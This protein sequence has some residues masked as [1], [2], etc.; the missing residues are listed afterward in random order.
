MNSPPRKEKH[1]CFRFPIFFI[2][3]EPQ[4]TELN[5]Y[6]SSGGR[7]EGRCNRCLTH[8]SLGPFHYLTL[9]HRLSWKTILQL[10]YQ[11]LKRLLKLYMLHQQENNSSTKCNYET[12][13]PSTVKGKSMNI[14]A[15]LPRLNGEMTAW[16][17]PQHPDP[18]IADLHN[19]TQ[20]QA[21]RKRVVFKYVSE[22][23]MCAC[24]HSWQNVFQFW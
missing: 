11:F 7:A 24:W 13:I 6:C 5:K 9:A 1:T 15:F 3:K 10:S 17:G 19:R 21:V 16:G 4:D 20:L 12:S 8:Y 18:W 23:F 2:P 22:T 14:Y